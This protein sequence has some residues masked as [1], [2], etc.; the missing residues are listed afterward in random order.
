MKT[1]I[2]FALL[3]STC[4]G[5]VE[6]TKTGGE[7][8]PEVSTWSDAGA[9]DASGD[10]DGCVQFQLCLYG[11]HFDPALC[12]CVQDEAGCDRIH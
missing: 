6:T 3:L 8:F 5:S 12:T 4:G 10:A 2:L 1:S 7:S 11:Q 9:L